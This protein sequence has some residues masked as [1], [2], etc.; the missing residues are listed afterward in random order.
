[1]SQIIDEESILP[2]DSNVAPVKSG[3]NFAKK[4]LA[5]VAAALVVLG[6]VACN[7]NIENA[8]QHF[9]RPS[10]RLSGITEFLLY[11]SYTIC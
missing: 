4:S 9:F 10:R 1:M 8:G 7:G 5:S 6:F 11:F 2:V 3:S